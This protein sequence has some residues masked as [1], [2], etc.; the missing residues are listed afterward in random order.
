MQVALAIL[1]ASAVTFLLR[2]LLAFVK[3]GMRRPPRAMEAYLAKFG[4]SRGQ[5]K[6]IVINVQPRHSGAPQSPGGRAVIPGATVLAIPDPDQRRIP[7]ESDLSQAS[8]P[9]LVGS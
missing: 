3:E 2:V 8:L 6:L 7:G 9:R 1:C 4:S 5:G